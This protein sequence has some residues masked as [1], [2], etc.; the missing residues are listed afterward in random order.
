MDA[1]H[2][3]GIHRLFDAIFRPALGQDDFGFFFG[4]VKGKNLGTQLYATFAPD[5]FFSVYNHDFSHLT[6]SFFRLWIWGQHPD[7]KDHPDDH[8][9]QAKCISEIIKGMFFLLTERMKT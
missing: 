7:L 3:A 5:A 6:C 2:G 8:T 4:F 9:T 1:F